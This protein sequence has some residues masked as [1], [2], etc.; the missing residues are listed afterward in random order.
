MKNQK[1]D[2]NTVDISG[3]LKKLLEM[4]TGQELIMKKK[5][6]RVIIGV[7]GHRIFGIQTFKEKVVCP[8]NQRIPSSLVSR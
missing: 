3:L 5:G 8:L 7:P 4:E 6:D 1:L 2:T